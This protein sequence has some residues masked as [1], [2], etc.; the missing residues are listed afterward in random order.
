VDID[1][2]YDNFIR[3]LTNDNLSDQLEYLSEFIDDLT[4]TEGGNNEREYGDDENRD[5]L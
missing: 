3:D 1:E 4:Q 5:A 2:I